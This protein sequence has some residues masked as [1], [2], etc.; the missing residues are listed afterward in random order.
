MREKVLKVKVDPEYLRMMVDCVRPEH[1]L[2]RRPWTSYITSV[3]MP[4]LLNERT[5]EF[6]E[7]S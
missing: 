5:T 6:G 7:F 1:L 3:Q 4:Y 2:S